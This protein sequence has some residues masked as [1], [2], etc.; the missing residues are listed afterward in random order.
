MRQTKPT[1]R[2]VIESSE[3]LA[4]GC[5]H[6]WGTGVEADETWPYLLGAM[7]FGLGCASGD[8]VARIAEGLII[9]YRPKIVYC[10]WPDWSRFEYF[11][12]GTIYQSLPT[13]TN[14]IHFMETHDDEWCKL[15]F[16]K[17][18]EDLKVICDRYGSKLIDMTLYDL[19]PY[20]DHADRWPLSKLGHH[21]APEW[22]GWVAELF[23]KAR[24][25]NFQFPLAHE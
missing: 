25:E 16:Q 3:S 18:T 9:N 1:F 4:L 19:I 20:I 10:L 17:N 2:N 14:R 15:N 8:Q 12:N 22:H 5:S 23:A 13:D 21:Y 11:T 7:N 24:D 6:T